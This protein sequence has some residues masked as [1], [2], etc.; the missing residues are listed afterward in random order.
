MTA[1][2]NDD[3]SNIRQCLDGNANAFEPLVR[4]YQNAAFAVAMSFLRD[5]SD[6]EDVVQDAFVAAYCKLPQLKDP[7]IFGSWLH[8][9]VVNHCKDWRRRK[10]VDRLIRVGSESES[11][12]GAYLLADQVHRNYIECLELWDEVE[13]LPEHYRHVVTL[14]Y[15]TGFSL[16]EIAAFL[17]IRESTVRGRLY[18]SRIRLREA[19]SPK[20]KETIAMSQID[21]TEEVQDVVCKIATEGFEETID[22]GDVEHI[23]LYCGVNTEVDIGQ[24]PGEQVIVKGS[25]IALGVTD[26]EAQNNV[27]GITISHDQVDNYMET[28]P[29]E[30][31]LFLSAK[32]WFPDNVPI[33]E[34]ISKYWKRDLRNE[35]VLDEKRGGVK[36]VDALPDSKHEINAFLPLPGPAE[37]CLGKTIRITVHASEARPIKMSRD[38]VSD[39]VARVFRSMQSDN[40]RL[41]GPATYCHVSVSV[42]AGKD[43]SIFRSDKVNV[44]GLDGSLMAY[45]CS[46]CRI[47]EITGDV[48]LFNSMFSE[49]GS[50]GGSLYQ[51]M[52]GYGGN[53]GCGMDGNILR[54]IPLQHE[55]K[56]EAVK[57]DVD[58]DVGC[59]DLNA[60]DL[61][62][63]IAIY[64]RYGKTRLCQSSRNNGHRCYVRSVS[65]DVNLVLDRQRA[66][67]IRLVMH[68][69]CGVAKYGELKKLMPITSWAHNDY[70]MSLATTDDFANPD[71]TILT[72]SGTVDIEITKN[73]KHS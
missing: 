69:I 73:G 47:N 36:M 32:N 13:N 59:M 15:Y 5:R 70:W 1:L 38:A 24:A 10:S 33:T 39:N 4:R 49:I 22:M 46:S 12:R 43:I 57:G 50:V 53:G 55:G 51:R 14:Y 52:Y 40:T 41:Y 8:R 27:D 21:V 61:E 65:G 3:T 26:E 60:L 34:P 35:S 30:G 54:R 63:D 17:D 48:Y 25:K 7:A 9:I 28:G 64:N 23:V 42:P 66:E 45:S 67:N 2:T 68:T 20:E 16:K 18:Q 44:D 58:I 62:G 11:V 56:I 37:K 19:L 71:I 6:A 29:H 72:E 31:A